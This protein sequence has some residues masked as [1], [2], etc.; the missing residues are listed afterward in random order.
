M[1]LDNVWFVLF[2]EESFKLTLLLLWYRFS[3]FVFV[4]S[5]SVFLCVPM[6]LS[7]IFVPKKQNKTLARIQIN[8]ICTVTKSYIKN[9]T[10][11]KMVRTIKKI[12][13]SL[14]QTLWRDLSFIK[15]QTFSILIQIESN[16]NSNRF[17][18]NKNWKCL[19]FNK[20]KISSKRLYKIDFLMVLTI[21]YFCLSK[22]QSCP[23]FKTKRGRQPSSHFNLIIKKLNTILF[24][25]FQKKRKSNFLLIT[26]FLKNY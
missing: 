4:I 11:I 23:V 3:S 5:N 17:Y 24:S 18:L 16:S 10:K 8:V 9:W 21:F 2:F 20:R 22:I 7:F 6:L 25:F 15:K 13:L 12:S 14:I 19:F 26:E 1:P